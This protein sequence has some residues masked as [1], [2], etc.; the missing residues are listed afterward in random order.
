MR[1]FCN[2]VSIWAMCVLLVACAS[3]E[4]QYD[5]WPTE[6]RAQVHVDLARV[7]LERGQLDVAKE[8][9]SKAREINPYSDKAVHG[10]G[11]I[12]AQNLNYEEAK[13]LL[14]KAVSLNHA[15]LDAVA[16]YAILL[17]ETDEGSRGLELLAQAQRKSKKPDSL[18][19]TLA[20]GRCYQSV[21]ELL[22]AEKAFAKALQMK[23][24]LPQA[25]YSMAELKLNQNQMLPARGLIQRY[26]SA[27]AMSSKA[28]LLGA[29][30]EQQLSNKKER[31]RY[32]KNLQT[33]YPNSEAWKEAQNIF[34]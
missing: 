34:K 31:N 26:F 17:C 29:K 21:G 5:T 7:Y 9:F 20:L 22:P 27:S 14:S 15:N 8:E 25:L 30:I 13:S 16:D 2:A 33:R 18:G 23:P 6:K 3:V 12:E 19:F 10:L 1:S 24:D 4:T 32:T 28:L 11:L